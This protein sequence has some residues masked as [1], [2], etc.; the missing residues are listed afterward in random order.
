MHFLL[1]LML[2]KSF[3]SLSGTAEDIVLKIVDFVKVLLPAYAA[4]IGLSGT[5]GYA[6]AYYELILFLI[7]CVENL[8]FKFLLPTIKL[9]VVLI[10]VAGIWNR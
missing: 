9:Y 5:T 2:G 1:M 7:F 6:V 3:F 4:A 10:F 8:L